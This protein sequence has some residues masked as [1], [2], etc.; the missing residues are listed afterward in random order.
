MAAVYQ[1]STRGGATSERFAAY[2]AA[3]ENGLPVHGYNPMT[4]RPVGAT[5]DALLEI[6]AERRLQRIARRTAAAFDFEGDAVMYLTVATPG[7]WTDRL[8]TEVD[9]R[10]NGTN[11]GGVLWWFDDTPD[12]PRFEAECVA[13]TVRMIVT[14]RIGRPQSLLAAVNQEGHAYA[15]CGDRR[16]LDPAA[17]EALEI[18]GSD[19]STS[20]MVAFLWGDA[21]A[22]SLCYTPLGLGDRVGYRHAIALA[23][24]EHKTA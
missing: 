15:A 23:S 21:A 9:H 19:T 3:A 8:A 11:P 13:Q 2:A 4:S 12:I 14:A 6:D 18:V 16:V 17:S 1:R 22:T 10:L 20:T 5:I 7:M 24:N